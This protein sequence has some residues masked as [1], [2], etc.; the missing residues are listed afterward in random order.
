MEAIRLRVAALLC[1]VFLQGCVGY[2]LLRKETGTPTSDVR[3]AGDLLIGT[4]VHTRQDFLA[5]YG[6]PVLAGGNQDFTFLT[7]RWAWC[8]VLVWVVVPVPLAA[9]VCSETSQVQFRD[10]IAVLQTDT[11]VR[12]RSRLC[13]PL[14]PLI[15]WEGQ[16]ENAFCDWDR[17]SGARQTRRYP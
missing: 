10:D 16:Y 14:M 2:T 13:G 6:E 4:P 3:V 8:G 1:L 9:P 11:Q 15:T 12:E 5:A 7:N 17:M